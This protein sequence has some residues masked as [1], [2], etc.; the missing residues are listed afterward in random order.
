MANAVAEKLDVD[1]FLSAFDGREGRWELRG[2]RPVK[3][4]AETVEHVRAKQRAWRALDDAIARAGLPCEAFVDGLTVRIDRDNAYEPDALVQCGGSFGLRSL[5][6]TSPIIVVEVL[7]ASSRTF[8][9][10]TKKVGYFSLPS[11]HHYL[12]VDPEHGTVEHYFRK[13]D[14]A[15]DS[16]LLRSGALRLDPPGL[17]LE[18]ASLFTPSPSASR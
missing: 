14:G 8:D 5:E 12:I 17:E 4:S 6:A 10:R 18:V 15:L 13:A 16:V 11:L 9:Q 1:G 2:G 7:S 3:L